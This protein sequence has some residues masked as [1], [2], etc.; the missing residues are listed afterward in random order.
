MPFCNLF[1]GDP[2]TNEIQSLYNE[3]DWKF[4]P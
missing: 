1:M 4:I 3:N 2:H